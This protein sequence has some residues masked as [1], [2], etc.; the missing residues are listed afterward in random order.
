MLQNQGC[1]VERAAGIVGSP[2]GTRVQD[3]VLMVVL[4]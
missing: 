1:G 3:R 4:V 2:G